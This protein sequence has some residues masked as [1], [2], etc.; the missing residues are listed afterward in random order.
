MSKPQETTDRVQNIKA[1]LNKAQADLS[2]L[3]EDAR[4]VG[5]QTLYEEL[6]KF[7]KDFGTRSEELLQKHGAGAPK[8]QKVTLRIIY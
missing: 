1:V 3:A 5:N 8:K 7:V 2:C 6:H 4:K